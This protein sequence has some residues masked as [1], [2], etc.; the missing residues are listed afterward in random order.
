MFQK[1]LN[2]YFS[3]S[4][5]QEE[6]SK[7]PALSL[8]VHFALYKNITDE[9]FIE[10]YALV[11]SSMENM[12]AKDWIKENFNNKK[13][14]LIVLEILSL[15]RIKSISSN[16]T[17]F[18][19][20]ESSKNSDEIFNSLFSKIEMAVKTQVA[21]DFTSPLSLNDI[22]I[23]LGQYSHS[24][25]LIEK[26]ITKYPRNI[27]EGFKN[28]LSASK[29][30]SLISTLWNTVKENK[31]Y[32]NSILIWRSKSIS[33]SL[34]TILKTK[35][36]G[37][38]TRHGIN[39]RE[40]LEASN[41]LLSIFP[42]NESDCTILYNKLI[43]DHLAATIILDDEFPDYE[44][45]LSSLPLPTN[46]TIIKSD[47]LPRQEYHHR[48][49][50]LIKV[51]DY[52]NPSFTFELMIKSKLD[53]CIGRA[54]QWKEKNCYLAL[55]TSPWNFSGSFNRDLAIQKIENSSS[56][57][58]LLISEIQEWHRKMKK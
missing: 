48:L 16:K 36:S 51:D 53:F 52:P 37:G 25:F 58:S 24:S 44:Q 10:E 7:I 40:A 22:S 49:W 50:T 30:Q 13:H 20:L 12:T 47:F 19:L 29:S 23:R 8:L 41:K 17:L 46:Y 33:S 6:L 32:T 3:D 21:N 11:F 57:N 14:N 55:S 34:N 1:E 42:Q 18:E 4:I 38:I 28:S 43:Y 27:Y 54:Y 39:Q 56:I 9:I 26:V 35:L 45:L 2:D 31:K 15:Y 5:V